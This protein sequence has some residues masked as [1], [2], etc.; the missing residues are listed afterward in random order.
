MKEIQTRATSHHTATADEI[1]LRITDRI[2][3]VFAPTLV[4]N[5]NNR[6]ACVRG[7]FV[8]QKKSVNDEW[9]SMADQSLASLKPGE[10]FK[11]ELHSE[12]LLHLMKELRPLYT[13]VINEGV[14]KGRARFVRVQS[15]LAAFFDLGERRPA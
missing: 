8:Y 10:H 7:T 3:L 2:R 1:V 4:S 14:P 5:E 6:L 12:E 15:N 9:I 11:L 13:L